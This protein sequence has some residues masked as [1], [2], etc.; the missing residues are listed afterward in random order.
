MAHHALATEAQAEDHE[1][2][3]DPMADGG[4]GEAHEG[5]GGDRH[6]G[7]RPDLEPVR[8]AADLGE[9]ISLPVGDLVKMSDSELLKVRS[10]GKT[11]LREIQRKLADLG[12]TLGMTDID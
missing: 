10:F 12:L 3:H 7:E 4:H 6:E 2:Q 11:S 9:E 1:D 8:Q 5:E